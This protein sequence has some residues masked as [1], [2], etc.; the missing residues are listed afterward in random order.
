MI[1]TVLNYILLFFVIGIGT[2]YGINQVTV[3]D[4]IPSEQP[5]VDWNTCKNKVERPRQQT[6]W[7]EISTGYDCLD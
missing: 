5:I 6:V 1:N 2:L 7:G 4:P 3:S